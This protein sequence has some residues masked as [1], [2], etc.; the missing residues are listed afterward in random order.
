MRS[1]GADQS[2]LWLQTPAATVSLAAGRLL[3]AAV[4]DP[5]MSTTLSVASEALASVAW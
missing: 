2:G 3:S 1:A 5:G 4:P